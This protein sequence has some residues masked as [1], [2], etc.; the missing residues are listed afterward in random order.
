[1]KKTLIVLTGFMFLFA[2]ATPSFACG[3]KKGNAEAEQPAHP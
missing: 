2:L 1:M 3:L